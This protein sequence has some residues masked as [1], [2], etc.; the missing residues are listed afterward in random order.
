MPDKRVQSCCLSDRDDVKP[1][2][3]LTSYMA[4]MPP[5]YAPCLCELHH[6]SLPGARVRAT[7]ADLIPRDPL[8]CLASGGRRAGLVSDHRGSEGQRLRTVLRRPDARLP[9]EI[10]GRLGAAVE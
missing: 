2:R 5:R 10:A 1:V 6:T 4:G 3:P 7:V 9:S 8:H